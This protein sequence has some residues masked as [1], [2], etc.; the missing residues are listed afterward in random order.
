MF[1][2]ECHYDLHAQ[3]GERCPEC[4]SIFDRADPAT[5]YATFPTRLRRFRRWAILWRRVIW[6]VAGLMVAVLWWRTAHELPV[7]DRFI[8]PGT[9]SR[10]NLNGL[11]EAWMSDQ[12]FYV[13]H[14]DS[15]SKDHLKKRL[16]LSYSAVTQFKVARVRAGMDYWYRSGY[17]HVHLGSLWILFLLL[18]CLGQKNSRRLGLVAAIVLSMMVLDPILGGPILNTVLPGTLDYVDDYV[19]LPDADLTSNNPKRSE[20]V[21]AYERVPTNYSRTVGFGYGNLRGMWDWELIP[22]LSAQG[23]TLAPNS[24]PTKYP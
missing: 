11:L 15:F 20:I 5:F 3:T 4:G 21:V 23:H 6:I 24:V 16:R 14:P 1:C 10:D 12:A 2:I 8:T 9:V 19:F 22:L 13:G 17:V 18:V 7:Q